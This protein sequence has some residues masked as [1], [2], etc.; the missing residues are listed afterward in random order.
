MGITKN[1]TCEIAEVTLLLLSVCLYENLIP[2]ISLMRSVSALW[3]TLVEIFEISANHH[4]AKTSNNKGNVLGLKFS[5]NKHLLSA[6]QV[7][8]NVLDCGDAS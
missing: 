7:L 5:F 1:A 2:L 8:C 4:S 6:S 3:V